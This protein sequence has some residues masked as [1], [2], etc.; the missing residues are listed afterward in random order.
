M[1]IAIYENGVFLREQETS[2]DLNNIVGLQDGRE[3]RVVRNV[4]F[5]AETDLQ[6]AIP[7]LIEDDTPDAEFPHLKMRRH[8]GQLVDR[9]LGE[10]QE[11]W[12][13]KL[14]QQYEIERAKHVTN[15]EVTEA[16]LSVVI[17]KLIAAGNILTGLTAVE[18]QACTI[19]RDN[20]ANNSTNYENRKTKTAAINTALTP[21]EVVAISISS[22][23]A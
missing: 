15:V 17:K 23:W 12:K 19:A 14:D 6:K 3:I 20:G 5:P 10:V 4:A 11:Y 22:G 16:A 18:L 13:Q 7:L 8:A 9:S 1:K 21:A 2:N